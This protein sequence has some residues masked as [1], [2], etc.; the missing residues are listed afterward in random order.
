M[1][2]ASPDT[3]AR[4][5]R[6]SNNGPKLTVAAPHSP[7]LLRDMIEKADATVGRLKTARVEEFAHWR[8]CAEWID[9]RRG[10]WLWTEKKDRGKL[11]GR[12]IDNVAFHA[13]KVG[14][15]N[16]Q[17]GLTS[18]SRAWF[19]LATSNLSLNKDPEAKKWLR[20]VETILIEIF[21]RS[22]F[23]ETTR[24]NYRELFNF[25]QGAFSIVPDF[26]NVIRCRQHTIGSY[27]L[28][29][30]SKGEVD[31][32]SEEF[33]LTIGQMLERY[34][35]EKMSRS[36][37]QAVREKKYEA[38]VK[39]RRL[40][41]PNRGSLYKPGTPGWQGAD[42]RVIE[43]DPADNM[44]MPLA[45]EPEYEF[46]TIV[47]RWE[48]M[49]DHAYAATWPG[50][51]ALGDVKQYQSDLIEF[52]RSIQQNSNPATIGDPA[53]KGQMGRELRPGERL[54]ATELQGQQALRRAIEFNPL[55]N[56]Q[57]ANLQR[58]ERKI[59]DR[60]HYDVF[61]AI[62]RIEGG[63]MRVVE[64]D[65][66]VREQMSQLGPIV[67]GLAEQQNDPAI[68]RTY[69]IAERAGIIPE[70]PENLVG[71]PIKVDYISILAQSQKSANIDKLDRY[72]IAATNVQQVDP[73]ARHRF[74]GDAW[75]KEQAEQLGV[76]PAVVRSDKDY[77]ELVAQDIQAQQQAAAQQAAV[78][79]AKAA[80]DASQA[81]L[82]GDTAL[83][84][85]L[86]AYRGAQQ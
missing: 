74:N 81:S 46:P 20:E 56:E 51:E 18:R 23:Y 58:Q 62:S 9:P 28:G 13:S 52:A 77:D 7:M 55:I 1:S 16:M 82:E 38:T 11:H 80:R 22:N 48:T 43:W 70:P 69:R 60:Y 64:I 4:D 66:R 10:E 12:I 40:I 67:E 71:V 61:Q 50:A 21:D 42:F 5:T 78:D 54:F 17:S 3:G 65:A 25:G 2:A 68:F 76:P 14:A 83:T 8:E 73:Y 75:M 29:I 72:F 19:R 36:A 37:Q 44:K 63:N 33:V 34:D 26:D 24:T 32:F 53:L 79:G 85:G 15:A 47:P 84:A 45:L 6:T 27:Y 57:L 49:S 31:T 59:Q 35:L 86:D 41:E 39:I 30:S